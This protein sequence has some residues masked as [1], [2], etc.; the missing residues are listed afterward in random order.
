MVGRLSSGRAFREEGFD[1]NLGRSR[2]ESAV[3]ASLC[4]TERKRRTAGPWLIWF[5]RGMNRDILAQLQRTAPLIKRRWEERLRAEPV[6]SPF[7]NADAL[8]ALIPES[9]AEVLRKLGGAFAGRAAAR[10]LRQEEPMCDCGHNPYRAYFK[11]GEQA[12]T[13]AL[14]LAQTA[15]HADP[16]DPATKAEM[17]GVIDMLARPKVDAFCHICSRY[18][19]ISSCRFVGDRGGKAPAG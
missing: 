15:C 11:A 9:I 14:V 17:R 10:A 16:G 3:L 8:A 2:L 12:M 18:Q 4:T 19:L 13:E 1:R 5:S 6:S 7:A